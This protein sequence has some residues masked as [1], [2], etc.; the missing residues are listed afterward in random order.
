MSISFTDIR[1]EDRLRV[2]AIIS[3]CGGNEISYV[4]GLSYC[5]PRDRD[6]AKSLLA[7]LQQLLVLTETKDPYRLSP[8]KYW[9]ES[10]GPRENRREPLPGMKDDLYPW[11][12]VKLYLK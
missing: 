12:Y 3:D 8:V 4:D 2:R 7:V 5:Q 1:D 11:K 10:H 6:I 9:N